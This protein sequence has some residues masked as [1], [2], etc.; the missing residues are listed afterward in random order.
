[1]NSIFFF[2]ILQ[3]NVRQ[4]IDVA[5]KITQLKSQIDDKFDY[6]RS[7]ELDKF[8]RTSLLLRPLQMAR[9]KY[10]RPNQNGYVATHTQYEPV[11]DKSP[12]FALHAEVEYD[13]KGEIELAWIVIVDEHLQVFQEIFVK[14]YPSYLDLIR[15]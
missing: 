8:P 11:T 10:P 3:E 15:K 4:I 1:M 7:F 2:K 6:S 12:L 5:D 13:D 14:P 9:E